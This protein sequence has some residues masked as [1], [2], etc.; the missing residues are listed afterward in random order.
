MLLLR[1]K[2]RSLSGRL[3]GMVP[4]YPQVPFSENAVVFE[5][6]IRIKEPKLKGLIPDRW[7]VKL[8][9]ISAIRWLSAIP[10]PF[11]GV[12]LTFLGEDVQCGLVLCLV[13]DLNGNQRSAA[14]KRLRIGGALLF[15]EENPR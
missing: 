1:P 6:V 14:L 10:V 5:A 4:I 12:N 9:K 7:T 8:P 11:V 2:Y 15:M 13:R 3:K